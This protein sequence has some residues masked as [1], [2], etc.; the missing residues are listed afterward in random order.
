MVK[1]YHK[2]F[3]AEQLQAA[4]TPRQA[5][6][7]FQQKSLHLSDHIRQKM[8]PG[9]SPEQLFI[10]ARDAALFKTLFFSG[11]RAD[12]LSFVKTQEIK[13]FPRDDGLLLNH[14][15][16]KTL[17]DGSSNLFGIR[18]HSNPSLCPINGIELYID[19]S[20]LVVDLSTGFLF[21]PSTPRG[22][23]VNEHMGSST[24]QSRLRFYDFYLQEASIDDRETLHSFRAGAAITLALSGSKLND[25]MSHVG[26]YSLLAASRYLKLAQVLHPGSPSALLSTHD[27]AMNALTARYIDSNNLHGFVAAFLPPPV[28]ITQISVAC[29]KRISFEVLSFEYWAFEL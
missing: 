22:R 21:R 29:A 5:T 10:Y 23:I 3:T 20:V 14:V 17:R 27:S 28:W 12:D 2:A 16:G 26:W 25:I 6:P 19:I 18:H 11:D 15:W 4:V 9:I 1:D 13:R 8:L 7:L 24:I